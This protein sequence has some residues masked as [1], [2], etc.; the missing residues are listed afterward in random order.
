M[1]I[2]FQKIAQ[3]IKIYKI[4]FVWNLYFDNHFIKLVFQSLSTK[5]D[6]LVDSSLDEEEKRRQMRLRINELC[7]LWKV[8]CLNCAD[9]HQD[10]NIDPSDLRPVTYSSCCLCSCHEVDHRLL[11]YAVD[12]AG[13]TLP[14]RI[15]FKI[16]DGN[17]VIK[18]ILVEISKF[19]VIFF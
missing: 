12:D 6:E 16:V 14:R 17:M 4:K 2:N 13:A 1:Y 18:I 3:S 19:E 15:A 11:I 8:D 10:D 5:A 9:F 7:E